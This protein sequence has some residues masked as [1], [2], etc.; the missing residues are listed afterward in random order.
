MKRKKGVSQVKASK[1]KKITF[2]DK[3]DKSFHRR[4]RPAELH[5]IEAWLLRPPSA[6]AITERRSFL[7]WKSLSFPFSCRQFQPG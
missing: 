5:G 4:K 2:K 7:L 1:R 6:T 3:K